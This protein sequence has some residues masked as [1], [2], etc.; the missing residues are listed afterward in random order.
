MYIFERF[1]YSTSDLM[2]KTKCLD[3]KST[4]I[5]KLET[6]NLKISKLSHW[7]SHSGYKTTIERHTKKKCL[8][9]YKLT[10]NSVQQKEVNLTQCY[11]TSLLFC[12]T[13]YLACKPK[14][15]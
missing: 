11:A 12:F 3:T 8:K 5:H 2:R 7:C 4:H 1:Q 14:I 15:I 13:W 6:I 9:A 10:Y